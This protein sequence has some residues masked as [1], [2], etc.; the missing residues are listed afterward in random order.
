MALANTVSWETSVELLAGAQTAGG[1]IPASTVHEIYQYGWLR[2]G[3]WCAYALDRAGKPAATAAWHHWV[4]TTLLAHEHRV[5]EAIAAVAADKVDGQVMMPARFTLT[6]EEE[7]SSDSEEEWPN[8]QTDCYGFWLWALADHLRRGGTL[9]DPLERAARLV[10]RY[11]LGAAETP[12]Y[13]CW[14]EHPGNLHTSTLGVIVAG[15]RDIG[16]V[17]GDSAAIAYAEQLQHRL[18]GPEFSVAGSLV[19]FPG[20]TRVDGSLL[21]LGV[22]LGVVD[23]DSDLY[24]TTVQRID[25]ELRLPNGG[26][27]R[28]LGDTFYGGSQWILLAV[29][30]G[31]ARLAM[32][33]SETAVTL[34]GWIESSATAEG[35][36]PEQ[37][38][39]VVQS[40]H[41]L[42]YW[43]QK[44]GGTATPLL[45]SHAMH[46][47]LL[48]EIAAHSGTGQ[49]P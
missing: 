5:D 39:D 23:V 37:V 21:W 25:E 8:F 45:W 29:S 1:S 10:L 33:E 11:L 43:K 36:L 34:L 18:L 30:L 14:E 6:G 12:S 9:D 16:A 28:Y 38:A 46:I 15:L 20:D 35:W 24:R 19:R 49:Q 3:S 41:M 48:D 32:G 26:V 17:L 22:P 40:P 44:W 4:A 2:D 31:W 7:S 13:D 47:V 42:A 27:R